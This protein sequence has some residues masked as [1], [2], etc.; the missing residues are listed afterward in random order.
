MT[1][2]PNRRSYIKQKELAKPA[3]TDNP[4]KMFDQFVVSVLLTAKPN[5][6]DH[7]KMVNDLMQTYSQ[8]YS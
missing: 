7:V 4:L 8:L 2:R 3:L 1:M 5:N 6:P